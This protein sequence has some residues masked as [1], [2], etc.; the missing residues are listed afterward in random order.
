MVCQEPSSHSV[1]SHVR[2][3]PENSRCLFV[4]NGCL[5]TLMPAFQLISLHSATSPFH[6]TFAP[7]PLHSLAK[8]ASRRG[9]L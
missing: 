2:S 7:L 3:Q 9:N 8:Q 5:F 4:Q 1:P 6:A